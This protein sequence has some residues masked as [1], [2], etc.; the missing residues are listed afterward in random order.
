MILSHCNFQLLRQSLPKCICTVSIEHKSHI[1][2]VVID[3][4]LARTIPSTSFSSLLDFHLGAV[5]GLR[6]NN[7]VNGV[8]D[9]SFSFVDRVN[10]NLVLYIFLNLVVF[11]LKLGVDLPIERGT[12]ITPHSHTQSEDKKANRQSSHNRYS[13]TLRYYTVSV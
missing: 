10:H 2:P 7:I 6:C 3:Y 11:D 12:V 5:I 1:D 9:F 4:Y 8:S 13:T